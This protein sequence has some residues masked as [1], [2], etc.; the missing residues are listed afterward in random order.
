METSTWSGLQT[1]SKSQNHAVYRLGSS[2][3][4]STQDFTAHLKASR[5]IAILL[6]AGLSVPSGIPTFRGS[7]SSWRGI[8]FRD[9]SDPYFLKKDPVLFWQFYNYMRH[10]ALKA[11][12]NPGHYVLAKLAHV[13]DCLTISQNI[14]GK[15]SSPSVLAR[16]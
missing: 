10:L 16:Y 12:P 3:V 5:R 6:G 14:D 4:N 2:L 15:K 8:P 13:K 7:G 9:L 1:E 11:K